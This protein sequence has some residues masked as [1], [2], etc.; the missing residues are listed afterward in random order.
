[1]THFPM[2]VYRSPGSHKKPGGGTYSYCSAQDQSA[3]DALLVA[4]WAMTSA[5]AIEAAGDK[6]TPQRKIAKWALKKPKKRKPSKPLDWRDKAKL[7]VSV[8]IPEDDA[9]P[10]RAEMNVK[11]MEL[12]LKFDG[13]TS[14]RKL[15]Q[16]ILDTIK[17]V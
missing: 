10:T 17:E 16:M 14:D 8:T 9:P 3:L 1:M 2:M 7:V 13:R 5:E 6:A 15:S 4:G 12:G 11:G